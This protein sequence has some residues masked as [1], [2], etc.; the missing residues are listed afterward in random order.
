VQSTLRAH[1]AG[2]TVVCFLA[3][4]VPTASADG[5]T[6]SGTAET[7]LADSLRGDAKTAF[8]SANLLITNQ[9]FSGAS[10]KLNQAYSLSKDPRLLFNMALCE[11][12]LHHYARM[13]T[14]LKQYEHD[15]GARLTPENR[16]K[17]EDA[18]RAISNLVGTVTIA[19]AE[20]GAVVTIDD[21]DLG[22]TPL[23][24][25]VP[26]DLGAHTLTVR[27]EGFEPFEKPLDVAGGN[28]TAVT[29][30]L[31]RRV[32]SGRLTV[33]ADSDALIVVDDA[34]SVIGKFDG[35]LAP[36]THNIRVTESGKIP[37]ASSIDLHVGENRTLEVT[38]ESEKHG[39]LVWPW[40]VGGAA[41]A[42]VGA[43]VGGY[44]LFKSSGASG[45]SAPPDGTL[46]PG[47]VM[48]H[49]HA[50]GFQR[51]FGR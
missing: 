11:R 4:L 37:Y 35:A 2:R 51:S 19:V 6:A 31:V 20:S 22:T 36:G 34:P 25:P 48:L 43:A 7:S 30:T 17:V 42:A 24:A 9:D 45:E 32:P 38:L 16:Q 15:A 29:V 39:T 1:L 21:A 14:L 49:A 12:N 44:F 46:T 10:A 26:L 33:S 40:I 47:T 3:L 41:V 5:P 28:E 18:L 13:Q 27:K 23:E 8:D 50:R